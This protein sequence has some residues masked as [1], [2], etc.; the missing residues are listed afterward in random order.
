MQQDIATTT[1]FTSRQDL[2]IALII[3]AGGMGMAIAHTLGRTHRIILASLETEEL[4]NGLEDLATPGIIATTVRCDLSDGNSVAELG[5]TIQKLGAINALVH[6]A[7]VTPD[8]ADWRTIIDVNLAG[9]ARIE[10]RIRPLMAHYGAAVFIASGGGHRPPPSKPLVGIL[11]DPLSDSLLENLERAC[12]GEMDPMESYALSKWAMIRMVKRRAA[13]W[14]ERRCRILSMSPGI[15]DTPMGRAAD[16]S[17]AGGV[18]ADM[19]PQ[20]PLQRDGTMVDIANAVKFLISPQA[21]YITGT[22]LLIDGGLSAA[23]RFAETGER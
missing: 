15:I 1:A 2:P 19:R 16:H 8:A 3:G 13:S 23:L 5:D 11:D 14:G 6:V 10:N 22:D 17:V 9:A 4:R 7:A 12:G 20:I 18:K 21:A